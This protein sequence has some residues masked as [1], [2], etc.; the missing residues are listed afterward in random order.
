MMGFAP[1]PPGRNSRA[2]LRR[3]LVQSDVYGLGV[4]G[5]SGLALE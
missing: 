2:T 3:H 4:A 5:S 1:C